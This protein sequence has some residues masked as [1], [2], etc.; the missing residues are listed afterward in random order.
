MLSDPVPNPA[1]PPEK[2]WHDLASIADVE[3]WVI[4]HDQALQQN[5]TK[6]YSTGHGSCFTL[7]AGGE[8]YLHTTGDGDIVLDVTPEATW[9]APVIT[10]ATRVPQ[11]AS[12]IWVLP[13]DVLTQ[14]ILG[15]NSLIASS[16]IVLHHNF[17]AKR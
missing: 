1:E 8:I 17:K 2:P 15:L 9:A 7:A 10:A 6:A 3:L 16:R 11:P 14:L 5:I 12:Q 13:G 4:E